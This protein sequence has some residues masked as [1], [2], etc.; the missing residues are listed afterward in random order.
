MSVLELQRWIKPE[1]FGLRLHCV[2]ESWQ[3]MG[4]CKLPTIPQGSSMWCI[5]WCYM[6]LPLAWTP[7]WKI[8]P[9]FFWILSPITNGKSCCT[10]FCLEVKSCVLPRKKLKW[11]TMWY[12]RM[13][14]KSCRKSWMTQLLGLMCFFLI[15]RAACMPNSP[16]AQSFPLGK[17]KWIGGFLDEIQTHL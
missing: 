14:S 8:M 5:Q 9:I 7:I 11:S 6:S 16:G 2:V 15:P 13:W 3:L 1:Q 12:M 17:Q 10:Y 4:G